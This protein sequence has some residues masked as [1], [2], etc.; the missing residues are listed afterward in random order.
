[1]VFIPSLTLYSKSKLII[2]WA[3]STWQSKQ[4][5]MKQSKEAIIYIANI[6]S[7]L[8]FIQDIATCQ[9]L[10]PNNSLIFLCIQWG[11]EDR[12]H[13]SHFKAKYNRIFI[14]WLS[15]NQVVGYHVIIFSN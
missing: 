2:A 15:Q 13:Y 1:M 3:R 11:R 5:P 9:A 8:K 14:K 6:M 10:S 12:C 4:I 7:T